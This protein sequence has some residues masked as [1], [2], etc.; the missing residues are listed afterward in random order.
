M[1]AVMVTA[2]IEIHICERPLSA[3]SVAPNEPLQGLDVAAGMPPGKQG[4]NEG[5][6]PFASLHPACNRFP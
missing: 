3:G 5:G 4:F 2:K 6:R 1:A